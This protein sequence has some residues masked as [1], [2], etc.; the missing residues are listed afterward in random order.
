MHRALPLHVGVRGRPLECLPACLLLQALAKAAQARLGSVNAKASSK[1]STTHLVLGGKEELPALAHPGCL[2]SRQLNKVQAHFPLPAMHFWGSLNGVPHHHYH[3]GKESVPKPP[4][5]GHMC[6]SVRTYPEQNKG[7]VKK[8]LGLSWGLQVR[9]RACS[10]N[11]LA[12]ISFDFLL[13]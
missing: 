10:A 13:S 1:T 3:W 7:P 9:S 2:H 4:P 6:V 5:L 11:I 8:Q 12:Q